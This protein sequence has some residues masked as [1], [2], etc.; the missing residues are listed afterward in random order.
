MST[1][2]ID[3]LNI[4]EGTKSVLKYMTRSKTAAAKSVSPTINVKKPY[5]T[6]PFSSP[7]N[8]PNDSDLSAEK[9]LPSA[10]QFQ[11]SSDIDTSSSFSTPELSN[12]STVVNTLESTVEQLGA[13]PSGHTSTPIHTSEVNP[14]TSFNMPESDE[15]SRLVATQFAEA[16]STQNEALI[17]TQKLLA[18][19]IKVQNNYKDVSNVKYFAYPCS[20]MPKAPDNGLVETNVNIWLKSIEDKA[21]SSSFSDEERLKMALHFSLT[22]AKEILD[23]TIQKIGYN[24]DEVKARFSAMS[25]QI[26][27]NSTKLME[28]IAQ[29]KR[30]PGESFQSLVI[31]LNVL[32]ELLG[33]DESYKE[34]VNPMMCDALANNVSAKFKRTLTVAD[35]QSLAT[36]LEKALKYIIDHPDEKFDVTESKPTVANV[37]VQSSPPNNTNNSNQKNNR[38]SYQGNR[39]YRGNYPNQGNRGNYH[40]NRGNFNNYRGNNRGNFRGSYNNQR[41]YQNFRGNNRSSFRGNNFNRGNRN[42]YNNGHG[43]N[44]GQSNWGNQNGQFQNPPRAQTKCSRCYGQHPTIECWR[45]NEFCGNCLSYGHIQHECNYDLYGN[46]GFRSFP[47]SESMA[48]SGTYHMPSSTDTAPNP[49]IPAIAAVSEEYHMDA[50]AAWPV[51]LPPPTEETAEAAMLRS[52]LARTSAMDI[53]DAIDKELQKKKAQINF[54]N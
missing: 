49:A 46:S 20:P 5:L 34:A 47:P 35:K 16:L 13:L 4:P 52:L 43:Y 50:A 23:Q 10:P 18:D 29:I 26:P 30:A 11:T 21:P 3:A 44:N 45:Q 48:F 41:G 14:S 36:C 6:S 24:W 8:A 37:N 12:S 1:S 54:G 39:G 32:G 9:D 38:G 28:K 22:Q 15:L 33:A 31:R 27:E 25:M 51:A 19:A 40:G 2:K 42:G 7:P 53:S 17:K